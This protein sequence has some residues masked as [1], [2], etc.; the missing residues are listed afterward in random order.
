MG[1]LRLLLAIVVV[2]GHIF[3][4]WLWGIQNVLA[5]KAFF[6]IS[7]FYMA[8][9]LTERYRRATLQFYLNRLLRLLPLHLAVLAIMVALIVVAPGLIGLPLVNLEGWRLVLS[10][11]ELYPTGVLLAIMNVTL[12]GSDLTN[13][14]CLDT[15]TLRFYLEGPDPGRVGTCLR[16]GI[17]VSAF[18][19]NGPMWTIGI[20]LIFYAMAPFVV[21][22]S[23]RTLL[24]LT[25]IAALPRF[26]LMYSGLGLLPWHRGV[27]AFELVY[28]LI[29][30][31]AFRLYLQ[32]RE[33]PAMHSRPLLLGITGA[34]LLLTVFGSP[35]WHWAYIVVLAAA[36]PALF[37]ATT[38]SRLD[39]YLGSL[40]YPVYTCQWLVLGVMNGGMTVIE[41]QDGTPVWIAAN[42]AAV[43]LVSAAAEWTIVRP[44]E[45]IRHQTAATLVH[46]GVRWRPRAGHG[47]TASAGLERL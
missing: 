38:T 40:S 28:F 46:R 7:G 45:R 43:L 9:I 16:R 20:E 11:P 31:L 41:E 33:T 12:I 1:I 22:R 21:R 15:T 39:A 32:L 34:L 6:V 5:V 17:P 8:L 19:I 2:C 26:W 47:A 30:V 44:I 29:G 3:P 10:T 13:F 25:G 35:D 36:L 27:A 4:A 42:L 18:L 23:T 37:L 24:L 14:T